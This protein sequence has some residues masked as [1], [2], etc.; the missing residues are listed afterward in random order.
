MLDTVGGG[1]IDVYGVANRDA[2]C[3]TVRTN[4]SSKLRQFLRGPFYSPKTFTD[5]LRNISSAIAAKWL[6]CLS[7]L[8]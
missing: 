5:A 1:D 6:L 2:G 3:A 4:R 7:L 8:A